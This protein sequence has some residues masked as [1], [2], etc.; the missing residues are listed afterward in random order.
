MSPQHHLPWLLHYTDW[1]LLRAC[2]VPV[3]LVKSPHPYR[4]PT[5]LAALD[6]TRALAK[7]ATLDDEILRFSAT[8]AQALDGNVHAVHG[9]VPVPPN[10]SVEVLRDA[11]ELEKTLAAAEHTAIDALRKTTDL[12]GISRDLL[13]VVGRHPADAVEEVAAQLGSQIVALGSVARSG[14][15]R[16]PSRQ[17]RRGTR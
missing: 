4:R 15:D 7:P 16:L 17:H 13:H 12:L 14:L 9:Y 10:V 1:E 2:P 6:P 5:I 8:L 11:A 3:L